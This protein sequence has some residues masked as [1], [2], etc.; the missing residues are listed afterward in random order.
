MRRHFAF[1]VLLL[2]LLPLWGAE[3][4]FPA[5]Y[6]VTANLNVR[7]S[8]STSSRVMTVLP[9]G[10]RVRVDG[11]YSPRWAMIPDRYGKIGYVSTS[12]I[13]YVAPVNVSIDDV[14]RG[15]QSE[16]A[17]SGGESRRAS[18]GGG[19]V[20]LGDII[21]WLVKAALVLIVVNILRRVG[22]YVLAIVSMVM[23]KA[24]WVVCIPFYAMNWLQRWLSK[25]W[26]AM[27]KKNGGNDRRNAELREM[28]E[29]WKI[30][31]YIILTPLRFVNAV[32]FNLI[33]HCGFEFYNYAV[34]VV[35][36]SND[37]EGADNTLLTI[38]L[39][40]WRVIKYVMWHG[41]LTLIESAFW[42][43]V[44]TFVPALTLFHGTD[45]DCS[46]NITHA[47]RSGYSNNLSG[48]WN[49]GKGNFAGNGIYFAPERSTA[50]YYAR[51]NSERALIVCRVSLGNVLDLGLAPW[52][53]Y[54]QCGHANALE[55][56]KWG[57]NNGYTTGEW[58]RGDQ[59]WW[60]YC[61]YDWQNRYNQSWRIR[62]LYVLNLT[63]RL[64]QRIPGGMCHWL[65][66]KMVLEDI[67]TTLFDD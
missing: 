28:Y 57:L 61:M 26:R 59:K 9:A 27:Y 46:V 55:A 66:R 22:E 21:W 5:Y 52:R 23:Y 49:V 39:I 18:S 16:A 53:V 51:C 34:E 15:S 14:E 42:T 65:F 64:M 50:L 20:S 63:D 47:G 40:P 6:E 24:Y 31:L 19:S 67:M 62:P 11:L 43:V 25:P 35:L 48:I 44:D 41:G 2:C 10:Y 12:Y 17:E 1:F 4:E 32:Y 13:R 8:A 3:G 54:N 60:E 30:P 37:K 36:P 56:T 7:E 29:K 38:V 45:A 58:W 33:V